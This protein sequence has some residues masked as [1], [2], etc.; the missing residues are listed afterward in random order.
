MLKWVLDQ[1]EWWRRLYVNVSQLQ[2][3]PQVGQMGHGSTV[4]DVRVAAVT[5][6]F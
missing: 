6:Y 5:L 3:L 1:P 4:A 2:D